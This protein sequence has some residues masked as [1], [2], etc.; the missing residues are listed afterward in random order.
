[1]TSAAAAP[2]GRRPGRLLRALSTA[3]AVTGSVLLAV[4]G[5]LTLLQAVQRYLPSGGW[6]WTGEL[7]RFA[8]VWLTFAMSG[9][10]AARDG[11]IA[12]KLVDIVAGPRLLRLV[13]IVAN[14]TV[15]IVCLNL[16]YEAWVLVMEDDGQT[17][18]ALGMPM[19]FFYLIPLAGL[20]LTIVRSVV[21]IFRPEPEMD[22]PGPA[23]ET[24]PT[25]EADE[26]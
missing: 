15:A 7:A 6:V 2:P 5:L 12:L 9:Y 26:T 4:I 18:P 21:A 13:G 23:D 10:L 1:M 19:R 24:H 14:V 16:L 8:F 17:S 20:L 3:E 11:H 25:H 22:E